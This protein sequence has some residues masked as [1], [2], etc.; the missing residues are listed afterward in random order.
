MYSKG[1]LLNVKI[2][3]KLLVG[4]N[5]KMLNESNKNFQ[6]IIEGKRID[7]RESIR[8]CTNNYNNIVPIIIIIM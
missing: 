6:N 3:K 7:R 4:R 5:L 8:A 2:F 1:T